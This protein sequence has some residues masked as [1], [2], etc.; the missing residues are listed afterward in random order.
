[1]FYYKKNIGDYFKKAGRLNMLQHG[2]YTLLIDACY[3]REI[4]PTHDDAIEWTWAS[5]PDELSAVEFVLK[6]FFELIEGRYIQKRIQE[7]IEKYHSTA[8]TNQRIA[9]EREEKR[10]VNKT[11]R[12]ENSTKREQVVNEAPPNQEPRTK[13]HKQKIAK[14]D[15]A[16]SL[17][18]L[19]VPEKNIKAW[20][21]IR[22]LKKATNSDAAFDQFIEQTKLA[23]VSVPDAVMICILNDWRGFQA[24]WVLNPQSSFN[25]LPVIAPSVAVVDQVQRTKELIGKYDT[26]KKS[27][28]DGIPKLSTLIKNNMDFDD[29]A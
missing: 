12:T 5:T 27:K 8:A 6:K 26:N 15:F 25:N 11:N 28:P 19:D 22:K 2:A 24:K 10:R 9:I 18:D 7:E 20:L 16:N 1:M 23:G 14:F 21:A 3:D 13:N 17:L 4:F 29:S